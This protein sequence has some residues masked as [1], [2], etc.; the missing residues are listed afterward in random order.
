MTEIIYPVWRQRLARS[1]HV[2]RSQVQSKYYQV[3]SV[4][5]N[6]APKNRTMVFRGFL[7][8]TQSILSVTDIRSEKIE[9]WQGDNQSRFEICWYFSGSREQYRL[10]GEVALI[11][12]SL[13]P[14]Y[15]TSVLG[16][17]RKNSLLKQQ[18]ANLSINA[19]QPFYSSSPKAPFDEDSILPIPE[20]RPGNQVNNEINRNITQSN[21]ADHDNDISNNFCVV[22]FI[23]YTVD[24]LDLKSKP[25]Q[26]CLYDIQGNWKEHVVNP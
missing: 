15:E 21:V 20:D 16:N 14:N 6:G 17:Q 2:N 26:R 3:A 7:P 4:C 9:E 25:Q 18:W 13:E 1:L 19:K 12:N 23:P 11:S 10:A 22:V 8:D 24:Y 5:S